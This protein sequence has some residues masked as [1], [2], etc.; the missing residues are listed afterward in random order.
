MQASARLERKNRG[1]LYIQ[2]AAIL[3]KDIGNGVLK[4]SERL[5]P[6]AEL[7]AKYQIA[8]VTMRQSISVLEEEGLLIRIQGKGTFVSDE[9]RIGKRLILR[10]DW[11]SILEHLEGKKT[12]M[13]K[14]AR[15]AAAPSIDPK[16]GEVASAYR[17]MRR[18]HLSDDLPYALVDIFIKQEIYDLCPKEF[19]SHMAITLLSKMEKAKVHRLYQSIFFTTADPEVARLLGLPVNSA[20]GDVL[21]VITDARNSIVYI[22]KAKYRG[23]FVK[24]EFNS[25][26]PVT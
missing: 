21:R 10:S 4:P 5:P 18:V 9:P 17:Y 15:N 13:L 8:I 22:G 26:K 14:S 7:A 2:V 16:L 3:R 23:D 24:L 1:A 25:T 19:D 12:R 6:I 11:T 20:I